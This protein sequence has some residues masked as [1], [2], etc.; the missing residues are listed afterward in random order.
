MLR[1]FNIEPET[2]KP[3]LTPIFDVAMA[4]NRG[5]SV[6]ETVPD[7]T[8]TSAMNLTP[9]YLPHSSQALE[10]GGFRPS[11]V[12]SPDMPKVDGPKEI[13]RLNLKNLSR[14]VK[15]VPASSSKKK[16]LFALEDMHEVSAKKTEVDD[17]YVNDEYREKSVSAK[18][19]R[20]LNKS[21][22]EGAKYL[23]SL[24]ASLGQMKVKPKILNL[25][26]DEC[27]LA[28]IR[29]RKDNV[30]YDRERVVSL[31]K[32]LKNIENG[33]A[34]NRANYF[35]DRFVGGSEFY[36]NRLDDFLLKWI[37]ARFGIL[38]QRIYERL[39]VDVALKNDFLKKNE[40]LFGNLKKL[41]TGNPVFLAKYK[42]LIMQEVKV[43][44]LVTVFGRNQ[45]CEVYRGNLRKKFKSD[46]EMMQYCYKN[47]FR[48]PIRFPDY[49][50]NVYTPRTKL[51][52]PFD[53]L[54]LAKPTPIIK[55]AN[56]IFA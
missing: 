6:S 55:K 11:Y 40:F 25:S 26:L 37:L 51:E 30:L 31:K 18:F 21:Y 27:A 45:I 2:F 36:A 35:F 46:K 56:E 54:P 3:R 38:D 4:F 53:P 47:A 10:D 13:D 34:R 19:V 9:R 28:E 14:L 16:R 43:Q 24:M 7:E 44:D 22:L 23:S 42:K 1:F 39:T 12:P 41:F 32:E 29:N 20:G 33:S 52:T 49:S 48:T 5:L 50:N 8:T 17:T 15:P